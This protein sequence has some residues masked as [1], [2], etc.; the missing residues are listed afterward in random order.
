[1]PSGKGRSKEVCMFRSWFCAI[2][3]LAATLASS[4]A[5]AESLLDRYPHSEMV[6]LSDGQEM[7]LPLHIQDGTGVVL[8]GLADLGALNDYLEPE[9]LKALP[10]TPTQG[11]IA[12][13]NMNYKQTDLGS[14]K[15]LVICVAATRDARPRVP[16]LS[17][18]NDYAGLLAVYVPFLRGL[19]GDRTQDVLFTWKLF[20][21][22]ELPLRAGLDVWGFPKSPG[23]IDVVVSNRA[24]SFSVRH[25]GSLVLRGSYRRLLPWSVP[26]T[27]DA[28]LATPMDVLP[29]I[30]NGLAEN[31]SRFG[32][33]LPWDKFEVNPEHPWGAALDDVGF[34]PV[35]WHTMTDI[36]SVFLAPASR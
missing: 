3:M 31:K 8:A 6:T 34:T 32:F 14:Y 35:L 17:A 12:L 22:E 5:R 18:V 24:A 20:V 1:M 10:M 21:T 16:V 25:G 33:F 26:L 9:G 36:E 4:P 28:Y 27:I 15:E 30:T 11:F 7:A 29:T 19:V 2:A 13:Y 23:D